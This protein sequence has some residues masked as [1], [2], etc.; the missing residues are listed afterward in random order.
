MVFGYS[1]AYIGIS[2]VTCITL[3]LLIVFFLLAF[4]LP[5]LMLSSYV[6]V[7]LPRFN[8]QLLRF[9]TMTAEIVDLISVLS[10]YDRNNTF[11]YEFARM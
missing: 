1:C 9:S 2:S 8:V 6:A 7:C 10:F 5:L 11:E 4:R 3:G